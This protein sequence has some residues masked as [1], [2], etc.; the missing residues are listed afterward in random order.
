MERAL[1]AEGNLMHV[2]AQVMKTF[3]ELPITAQER[4]A[5]AS[6]AYAAAMEEE[7]KAAAALVSRLSIAPKVTHAASSLF[8][9]GAGAVDF[10]KDRSAFRLPFIGARIGVALGKIG[11][12]VAHE[13]ARPKRSCRSG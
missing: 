4:E 5:Y 7:A 8:E 12:D 2:K 11:L 10:I 1:I 3:S 9:S 6:E 13:F